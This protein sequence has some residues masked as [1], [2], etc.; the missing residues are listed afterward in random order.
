MMDKIIE[1]CLFVYELFYESLRIMVAIVA[2][3]SGLKYL[4]FLV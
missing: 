2:I 3:L 1:S 4:G